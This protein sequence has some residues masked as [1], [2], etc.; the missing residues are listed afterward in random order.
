MN[1]SKTSEEVIEN[2]RPRMEEWLRYAYDEG[3]RKGNEIK[4]EY[5]DNLRSECHREKGN[6]DEGYSKQW[7]DYTP[8]YGWCSKCQKA[9]SGRWAHIWEFCPWCGSRI[10]HKAEEPYPTGKRYTPDLLKQLKDMCADI[11][12]E[13]IKAHDTDDSLEGWCGAWNRQM[14]KLIKHIA[15]DESC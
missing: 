6:Y 9:H 7:N 5:L 14:D 3:Y 8:F 2:Y 12:P 10:D 13:E 4:K 1:P 15:D 11:N